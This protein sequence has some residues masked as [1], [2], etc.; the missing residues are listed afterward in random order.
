MTVFD[1][2]VDTDDLVILGPPKSIDVSLDI[3]EKGERGARFILG[4]GNPNLPGVIP[5]G[6]E[7]K[8]GDVFLNSSTASNY[9]WLY[10]Y[11][12]TPFGNYWVSALKLQPPVYASNYEISTNSNGEATISVPLSDIVSDISIDDVSRYTINLTLDNSN[13]SAVSII[14]RQIVGTSLIIA[15]KV[16]EFSGSSWSY[17]QNQEKIIN[18]T[19]SVV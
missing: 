8:V 17:I 14:S 12:V 9:G 18:I 2:V 11:T 16:A 4:S 10:I 3:G 15:I 1:V 13:P 6:Q 7:V 19:V 5:N